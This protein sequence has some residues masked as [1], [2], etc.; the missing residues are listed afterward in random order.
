[1]TRSVSRRAFLGTAGA[2]A[3]TMAAVPGAS[4]VAAEG[5]SAAATRSA[6]SHTS[7]VV[8]FHGAHQAGIVTPAQDRLLFASFDVLT[9]D[10]DELVGML[11]EWTRASRRMTA[12]HPVGAENTDQDAPPDDTGEA[13]D[14]S[15]AALTVTFGFGASLFDREGDPFLIAAR[16]ADG[17]GPDAGVRR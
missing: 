16:Q 12:G 3:V 10:R 6:A 17:P 9:D 2:G 11:R 13:D 7:P 15:T 4:L 5:T 1:M 14:L 8:P